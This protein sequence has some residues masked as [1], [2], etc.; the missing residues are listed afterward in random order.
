MAQVLSPVDAHVREKS[1]AFGRTHLS[2]SNATKV[3]DV[4]WRNDGDD[5]FCY[6]M[7]NNVCEAVVSS[8][9]M[10]RKLPGIIRTDG[11]SIIDDDVHPRFEIR[12]E[13]AIGGDLYDYTQRH[14]MTQRTVVA[15]RVFKQ[16]L[17]AVY[18]LHEHDIVHGDL[19]PEN[20]AV[21]DTDPCAFTVNLIDFGSCA[22]AKY[23]DV[24][25]SRSYRGTHVFSAPECFG[26]WPDGIVDATRSIDPFLVDAYALGVVMHT[27]ITDTYLH[28]EP[29]GKG[30]VD[31]KEMMR[32]L[33]LEGAVSVDTEA[34]VESGCESWILHAVLD[35][36][37]PDPKRR[38]RVRH[39]YL[40]Y[41]QPIEIVEVPRH[42]RDAHVTF[43]SWGSVTTDAASARRCAVNH[44]YDLCSEH[45]MDYRPMALA[46][47]VADRYVGVVRRP[48]TGAELT[49]AYVIV[50]SCVTG[51]SVNRRLDKPEAR[52]VVDILDVLACDIY[53]ETCDRILD[54]SDGYCRLDYEL[55]KDALVDAEGDTMAAVDI[56]RR[57]RPLVDLTNL[58]FSRPDKDEG[59]LEVD[60]T[61]PK[62]PPK[63]KTFR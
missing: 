1:G 16:L 34:F 33:H 12:M 37:N 40:K 22:L 36:V 44:I 4:F 61:S 15:P 25:R 63:K 3:T 2:G 26:I 49:A 20:I 5:T 41:V 57:T 58:V 47:N 54:R 51:S 29:S 7:E 19:K 27:F 28:T 9:C 18:Q 14:T 42:I 52:A 55:L 62:S 13:R 23:T 48:A 60:L 59:R 46:L 21:S 31:E 35:L 32:N 11:V 8:Y 39:V 50:A 43:P 17:T 6:V 45:G 10:H 30:G 24:L 56:Y 38:A 53:S